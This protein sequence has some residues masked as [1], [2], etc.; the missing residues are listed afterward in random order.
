VTMEKVPNDARRVV[1]AL[2]E[3]LFVILRILDT[4]DCFISYRACNLPNTR[5]KS[6]MECSD[7]VKGPE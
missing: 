6:A 4:S 2:G 1:W 7:D 3:F 5:K